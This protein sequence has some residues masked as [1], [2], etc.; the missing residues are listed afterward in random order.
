MKSS[1]TLREAAKLTGYTQDYLGQ[2]IRGKKMQGEKVGRDWVTTREEIY[3]FLTTQSPERLKFVMRQDSVIASFVNKTA[4]AETISSDDAPIESKIPSIKESIRIRPLV[5]N[6]PLAVAGRYVRNSILSLSSRLNSIIRIASLP[7]YVQVYHLKKIVLIVS[8]LGLTVGGGFATH[9]IATSATNNLLSGGYA[10]LDVANLGMEIWYQINESRMPRL[11]SEISNSVFN[12]PDNLKWV[13]AGVVNGDASDVADAIASNLQSNI[14]LLVI[15]LVNGLGD[16]QRGVNEFVVVGGDNLIA[17]ISGSGFSPFNDVQNT[18]YF[19]NLSVSDFTAQSG[20]SMQFAQEQTQ[21]ILSAVID[22]VRNSVSAGTFSFAKLYTR[23]NDRTY[24]IVTAPFKYTIKQYNELNNSLYASWGRSYLRVAEVL[25]PGYFPYTNISTTTVTPADVRRFTEI[26]SQLSSE[27]VSY[28]QQT[29][30]SVIALQETIQQI[31]PPPPPVIVQVPGE[32]PPSDQQQPPAIFPDSSQPSPDLTQLKSDL[33]QVTSDVLR[34]DGQ[35]QNIN[36][37]SE[38]ITIQNIYPQQSGTNLNLRTMDSGVI[39]LASAQGVFLQGASII[40]DVTPLSGQSLSSAIISLKDHAEMADGLTLT[41]GDLTLNAGNFALPSGNI[42]ATS[43]DATG[44]AFSFSSGVTTGTALGITANS[45]TTGTGL[46]V[47]STGAIAATGA[48]ARLSASGLTSGDGLVITG[49]SSAGITGN[50]LSLISDV[51]SSGKLISLAPDFSGADVTGYGIY[52]AATDSTSSANTDYGYYGSLTL[53]GNA[54]KT[55]IGVYQTVTSSSTTADTLV[56]LD[57]TTDVTGI[58]AGAGTRN[59]YGLRSQPS[60]GAES[61]AGTTNVYGVYSKVIA[62]VAAGGTV[63]GYGLYVANGT[64][65]TDGTSTQYGLYVESPTGAGSN[66]AAIF[67]GGNVGIGVA[68]PSAPLE[69]GDGTDSI[70]FSSVGDI[71]FVDADGAASITGSTG[72]ALTVAAGAAQPLTLTANNASTWSTSNGLLTVTGDD[73]I[74][75][76]AIS[77]AGITANLP[78][79]LADALDVQQGT[80]NYINIS[81]SDSAASVTIDLPVVGSVSTI[82]NLFTANIAKTINLGTGTAADTINIGTDGTAADVIAIGNS[83]A[84]TTLALTGGDDW[85]MASTGILTMSASADQTTAIVITDTNYTNSLSIGDN[86]I[87]GTTASIDLT[88]FDITGATGAVTIDPQTIGTYLDFTLD[89]AW[90]SGTLIN[91]DFS[92]EATTQG[93]AAITGISLNLND[94]LITPSAGQSVTGYDLALPVASTTSNATVYTGFN[95]GTAGSITNGTA[96]SFV[97]RGANITLPI[98]TQSAG[99]S[100]TASGVRVLV[101]ASGAIVTAG[102]MNGIDVIAPTTSGPAAGTLNGVNISNL[103]SA[104]AG[105]ENAIQIGSGWDADILFVDTTPTLVIG[106]TGTLSVT[107]GTNI[108]FSIADDTSEGDVTVTGDLAVNG[109]TSADITSTTTAATV[110]NTTVN[111]LSVG[112]S[113]STLNLGI[114]DGITRIVNLGTGS[115]ADTINIGTGATTADAITLGN[116]SVATTLAF[117]TGVTTG[118]G[119][120]ITAN[121]V[122]SGNTLTISS[123]ALTTGEVIDIAAIYAPADGSTNEAIDINLTHNPNTS[124]DNFSGIDLD[125]SDGTVL[126]N[127]VYNYNGTLTLTGNAAKTGTGIYQTVTSSSTT[128]D[129]LYAADFLVD[130]NGASA[131]GNKTLYGL[132]A[133]ITNDGI[134]DAAGTHNIYGGYFA[135]TGNTGGTQTAYGVFVEASGADTNYGINVNAISTAATTNTGIAIG[136][137]S[138]GTT[139]NGITIGTNSSATANGLTIGAMSGTTANIFQEQVVQ[140]QE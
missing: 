139:S 8:L 50:I 127:T 43:S 128:G 7:I 89:N 116:T 131:S 26:V 111:T 94:N 28:Q 36:S 133:Q 59:V 27:V 32:Q 68:T 97:W 64:Y 109:A 62:D 121:S 122:N 6:H 84:S 112:G 110:F 102:T 70:Q 2:L 108:L 20:Q 69:I 113:A 63:N 130:H 39:M 92:G 38:N 54:A 60:A 124:A 47:S 30:Q 44:T 80:N 4:I 83:N 118:T 66:Y 3:N 75:L 137:L 51:G 72:G 71:T 5:E 86:T 56:S 53:A 125:I 101:P 10:Q 138:G 90:V 15:N 57:L 115:G 82:G 81:T 21:S 103:T 106:N 16:I 93:A 17:S 65:D 79:N 40:L 76:T 33:A 52:Q 41:G 119:F 114:T 95:L 126:D 67:A 117:N 104:G 99:G 88:Y 14:F 73:G 98:I 120:A 55:G 24:Q 107:D 34:I 140:E 96:G 11:A 1:I 49:P 74:T 136:N 58:M 129:T 23:A 13:Y 9:G 48:L 42:T 78:D 18:A 135:A 12:L 105:T 35:L 85:S 100:V 29:N 25:L 19:G 46:S 22:R 45:L 91:A 134:T 31:P 37:S 123:D 132:R 61:T 87:T 77:T